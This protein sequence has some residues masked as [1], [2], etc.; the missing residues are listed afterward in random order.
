MI[1]PD[2]LA[3]SAGDLAI[4]PIDHASLVL[5]LGKETV[6][7]DPVGGPARYAGLPRPTAILVTHEHGDHFDAATLEALIGERSTPIVTASGVA[8]K[9]PERLRQ[10]TTVL[11]YGDTG[12]LNGN[13]V[14][15]VAAHNTSPDRL[16]YHPKGLGNGYVLTLGGRRIYISGDTEP[17]PQ[18]L[19]LEGIDVAFLPMNLPYT[20]VAEQA[21]EAVKTFKP[22]IV[23]PFHYARGSEPENFAR[24]MQGFPGVEVRP[25]DWYALS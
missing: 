22:S 20:M 10:Q 12:T 1:E 14:L 15:A 5:T 2:T 16:R 18:M 17:T 6:Y 11:A 19:A 4:Q 13:P 9:L 7:V 23:Y 21:A 25:R 24:L 8:A 3:T